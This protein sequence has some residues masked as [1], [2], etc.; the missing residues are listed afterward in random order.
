M[1]L[2]RNYQ[3]FTLPLLIIFS[4]LLLTY[5]GYRSWVL[6]MT[7]DESASWMYFHNASF[8]ESLRLHKYWTS[9]NN[10]V[11]NTFLFRQSISI[12]GQSDWAVR[13]PN[14]LAHLIYLSSS[15]FIILQ[16]TQKP[17][18]GIC[19][20]ILL[21]LNPYLL[22]F[23]SL[24][25]GYG[26]AMGFTMLSL[27][28]FV[29][30]IKKPDWKWALG[31]FTAAGLSV[32]SNFTQFNFFAILWLTYGLF[33]LKHFELD[34][35]KLLLWQWQPLSVSIVLG[36]LLW[37]PILWLQGAGEFNWGV[38]GL[39]ETFW[40]LV[41][42]SLDNQ[43]Y[44]SKHTTSI[45][46]YGLATITIFVLWEGLKSIRK[47]KYTISTAVF[48]MTSFLFIG[49]IIIMV[50]QKKILGT[51]YFIHRTALIFIPIWGLLIFSFLLN[52]F[53]RK[54]LFQNLIGLLILISG[55]LH[56]SRTINF[57]SCREWWYD[58]NTLK[59]LNY[60]ETKV[61]HDKEVY[62]GAHWMFRQTSMYYKQA[63]NL[64]F[65]KNIPYSKEILPKAGYKY[66][67]VF[68]SNYEQFLQEGYEIEKEFE[69]ACLLRKKE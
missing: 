57:D 6:S 47:K 1:D 68:K 13:L 58:K 37:Q 19:G 7:H 66:Y 18:L 38:S 10:H 67:Y 69:F 53:N 35:K 31:I 16:L 61:P 50:L 56:F 34:F 42:D 26:L 9:A 25:R 29:G 52:F 15:I 39:K 30:F 44:F 32:L 40:V 51:Q 23:F 12:F 55:N 43:K 54:L 24:A 2:K 36:F 60:L 48:V 45:F 27:S 63:N 22:D 20:W 62:L 14:V 41:E 4:L 17:I 21:N 5:T 49:T 59:M 8:W 64:T 33:C 11:L 28:F 65:F 3:N 46:S